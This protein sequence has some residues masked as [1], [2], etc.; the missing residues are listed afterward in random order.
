MCRCTKI[1]RTFVISPRQGEIENKLPEVYAARK[2]TS[3]GLRSK[4]NYP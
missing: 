2:L 3:K 1:L 4:I